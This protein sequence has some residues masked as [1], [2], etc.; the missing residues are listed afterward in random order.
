MPRSIL[1][2]KEEY[3]RMSPSILSPTELMI[4]KLMLPIY[5]HM[6]QRSR[7]PGQPLTPEQEA[8]DAMVKR[9]NT[10]PGIPG[11]N[12]APV[13]NPNPAAPLPMPI[14]GRRA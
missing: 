8:W 14:T 2:V 9:F 13:Y 11:I 1:S 6:S 3:D 10:P 4:H 7:I 12:G 5:D